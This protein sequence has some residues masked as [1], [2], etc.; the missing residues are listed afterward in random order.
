MLCSV[1][2]V[3]KHRSKRACTEN[4]IRQDEQPWTL[5]TPFDWE[6]Y[7]F[8]FDCIPTVTLMPAPIFHFSLEFN[9]FFDSF[10]FVD[11]GEFTNQKKK[12]NESP[13]KCDFFRLIRAKQKR[14]GNK[15]E[16][17]EMR[18]FMIYWRIEAKLSVAFKFNGSKFIKCFW[19]VQKFM[20]IW[21]IWWTVAN[22]LIQLCLCLCVCVCRHFNVLCTTID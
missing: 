17:K 12:V 20:V 5:S 1:I 11:V 3:S 18:K 16:T 7:F 14:N 8:G 21:I 15:N 22:F 4:D 6:F 13:W 2:Y 10:F 19:S 9:F